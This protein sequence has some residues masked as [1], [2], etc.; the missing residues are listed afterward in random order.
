MWFFVWLNISDWERKLWYDNFGF[1]VDFEWKCMY[2]IEL[3]F[4]VSM[5]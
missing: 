4:E 1:N 2:M 5:Y 3:V